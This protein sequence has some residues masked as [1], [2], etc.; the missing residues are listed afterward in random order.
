MATT[1]SGQ[2]APVMA[3]T[4]SGQGAPVMATTSGSEALVMATH[5]HGAR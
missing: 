1:T 3:T 4:T 5:R 2:G